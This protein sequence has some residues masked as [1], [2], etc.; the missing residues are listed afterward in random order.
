MPSNPELPSADDGTLATARER[1][2]ATR[3]ILEVI[4]RS[5]DDEKPVFDVILESAARL[6]NA[7]LAFVAMANAERT[8]LELKAH[9]GDNFP[10]FVEYLSSTPL[11]LSVEETETARSVL[12]CRT[13]QIED[14]RSGELYERGQPHRITAIEEGGVRT[15][16]IVPLV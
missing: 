3:K 7:P 10:K 16:L 6:C 8:Q 14:L 12:E 4:S 11:P 15:L 2:E 5:R 1:E 9:K 13:I